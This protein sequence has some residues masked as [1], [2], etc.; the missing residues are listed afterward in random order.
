MAENDRKFSI[1]DHLEELRKRLFFALM[2]LVICLIISFFFTE[3]IIL[4]LSRPAG[5]L[6]NL[7]AIEVT[8]NVGVFMKVALLS[9]FTLSLPWILF[10]IMKFVIPGL[11]RTEKKWLFL[12]IPF[13][14][15]LFILGIAFAFFIMLPS[16]LPI[17]TQF[18]GITTT[19]RV[20]S[21]IDF[22]INLMFWI[23]IS[24]ELPL[25]VFILARLG[26]VNAKSLL[27]GWRYALIAMA[28]L[29]ALITPT[30]DPINMAIF[31]LP[32]FLL[33]LL[34]ILLAK[35]AQNKS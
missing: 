4:F 12:S 20:K 21:Y 3:N 30:V 2:G 16:A 9:G 17:L 18:L 29:A 35:L 27:N 6:E 34:S 10:Q 28:I 33:Y 11:T 1:L 24:F 14:T 22:I 31:M 26:I 8:E 25:I 15:F 19:I 32:L 13:A 5:G 7:Q 23:G